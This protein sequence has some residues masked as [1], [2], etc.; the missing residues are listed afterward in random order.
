[1]ANETILIVDDED[2][3]RD[4]IAM[5][6]ELS[7]YQCLHAG[8]ALEAHTLV[9][10]HRPDLILLDWMMPGISGIELARRLR[11]DN[12]TKNT[13]I[14]MLTAK[15]EEDNKVEGLDSGVDDYITKPFSTKELTARIKALLRRSGAV[16]ETSLEYNGLAIDP[17]AHRVSVNGDPLKLGPTE[18]RMLEFFMTHPERAYSR[19]QL[20]DGVWGGTVYIDDRTVDVHIRRLRKALEEFGFDKYIQTVRGTG[21]RFSSNP[22]TS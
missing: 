14:I 18:Y 3:I 19:E 16:E 12:A 13:P 6:L 22:E 11:R 20:L 9:I 7:G 1:M 2:S 15:G 4:M 8:T 21:Y 17:V 10:E 5:S